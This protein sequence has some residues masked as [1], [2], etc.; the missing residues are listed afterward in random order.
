MIPLHYPYIDV[1][2]Y[3][4]LDRNS[5]KRRYEYFDGEL[6]MLTGDTTYHS[7]VKTN[8]IG[9]F[10]GSQRKKSC[11]IFGSDIRLQLSESC[12]VHPDIVVSCDARDHNLDD[13]IRYPHLVVEVLSSNTE[14]IDRGK[15]LINYLENPTLQEYVMADSQSIRIEVYHREENGW[16]LHIYRS[17]DIVR[18]ASLDLQFS[19]A[20]VYEDINFD[21]M[22]THDVED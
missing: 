17:G 3:L 8:L 11:R 14:A 10:Y 18:L 12:Y 1:E 4:M 16:K 9:I 15:K 2:G 20:D 7:I 5:T 19:V 22:P 21:T 6:L 13:M